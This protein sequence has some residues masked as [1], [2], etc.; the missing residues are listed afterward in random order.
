[1]FNFSSLLSAHKIT[2]F[3]DSSIDFQ[4]EK[5]QIQNSLI[6]FLRIPHQFHKKQER[7]G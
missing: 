3:Y 6:E 2:A 5:I 1:M 7:K 4:Q